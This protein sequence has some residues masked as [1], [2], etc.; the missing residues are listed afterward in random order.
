MVVLFGSE[1]SMARSQP[2]Q[3]DTRDQKSRAR[4]HARGT[5]IWPGGAVC[6]EQR[7]GMSLFI[8]LKPTSHIVD[9][10]IPNFPM[11]FLVFSH[12]IE[13]DIFLETPTNRGTSSSALAL[14]RRQRRMV[15]RGCC[16]TAGGWTDELV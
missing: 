8:L 13:P 14:G 5:A 1:Q 3:D 12:L 15:Q 16:G 6:D 11:F 4:G 9:R 2:W 10:K 7:R